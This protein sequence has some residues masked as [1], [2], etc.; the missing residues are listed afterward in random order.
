MKI[1]LLPGSF[2]YTTATHE[3][4]HALGLSHPH[5]DQHENEAFPGVSND[6]DT[7]DNGLNA[8][9]LYSHDI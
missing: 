6:E 5:P 9:P 3:L 4:G 2:Y 7:G 8:Q 1:I